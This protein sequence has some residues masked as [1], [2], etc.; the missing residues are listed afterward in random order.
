MADLNLRWL[1]YVK[2]LRETQFAAH[3]TQPLDSSTVVKLD[4]PTMRATAGA[5]LQDLNTDYYIVIA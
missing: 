4:E 3:A 5:K 2:A 1:A